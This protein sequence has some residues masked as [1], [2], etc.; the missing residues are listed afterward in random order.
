MGS[1]DLSK[2]TTVADFA[3]AEPEEARGVAR[4]VQ[5]AV[6]Y[7]SSFDWCAGALD[8]YVGIAIPGVIG[9]LLMHIRPARAGVDEWL[10]IVVGDVPPAYLVTDDCPDPGAAL[11]GYISEM[12]RWVEAVR[13]DAS[14][15]DLIPVNASPTRE[16]ADMLASRLDFLRKELL[17]QYEGDPDL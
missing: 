13:R 10:W 15:E 12:E 16:F 4:L 2:V 9:V 6:A 11:D 3:A 7:V 8:T 14:V 17:S 5:Q 1:P